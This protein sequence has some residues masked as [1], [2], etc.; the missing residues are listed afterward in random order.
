MWVVAAVLGAVFPAAT[1]LFNYRLRAPIRAAIAL[2]PNLTMACGI[3]LFA[4][5]DY[6]EANLW[7]VGVA[8]LLLLG[9]VGVIGVIEVTLLAMFTREPASA[10][11]PDETRK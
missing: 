6:P 11:P 1:F 8:F 10:T 3:P 5:L 4:L 7:N 9:T 2:L